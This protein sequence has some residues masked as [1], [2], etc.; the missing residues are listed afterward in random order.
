MSASNL[1]QLFPLHWHV[2]SNN[3]VEL[4]KELLKGQNNLE[5]LDPRGRTP[6]MLAV[7]LGHLESTRLLLK[8]GADATFQD[9]KYWSVV[10]EATSTG[11]P[12]LVALILQ[13]RDAQREKKKTQNIPCLLKILKE[14]PDFYVE[15]KWEFSSWVPLISRVCPS[16]TYRV[17]KS[18]AQ[19]RIDTTLIGFDNMKWIRGNRSCV[20]KATEN[21][22]EVL[23][24]DHDT[25]TTRREMLDLQ[26]VPDQILQPT[27]DAV[28]VR[29]TSPIATTFIDVDRISFE[30]SKS[31]I[32]GWRSDRSETLNGLECKVFSASNVEIITQSRSEHLTEL[33]KKQSKSQNQRTILDSLLSTVETQ[34][35]ANNS[36]YT[37]ETSS[38]QNNPCN[39]TPEEYFNDR[40]DLQGRDIGRPKETS[41]KTQRFKATLWLSEEFPLNLQ[42]QVQPIID[43]M[44]VSNAH[45]QKLKDFITLQLPSGFPV[46][47]E[48]PLFHVINARITF[49]NIYSLKNPVENVH[50]Y[51]DGTVSRC[52][53]DDEVF[54]VGSNYKI[55]Q[56]GIMN[57]RFHDEDE[58]LLR[59]AIKQSLVESGTER[60]QVTLMEALNQSKPTDEPSGFLMASDEERAL[61]RALEESLSLVGAQT[62]DIVEASSVPNVDDDLM[63]AI[64]MSVREQ[65]QRDERR[66]K[67]DEELEQV[68][69]LSMLEK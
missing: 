53:I 52:T 60:D 67:E 18:G 43:L 2:W 66:R 69:K 42:E 31:G 34:K 13:H 55:L 28:A 40:I 17:W 49:D 22:A 46:K 35:A 20:F 29:L 38:T 56:S 36:Q 45:F 6:L 59:F 63:L 14:S 4:D 1:S 50:S 39:I 21:G 37:C 61:Q 11:D 47:I 19:V 32:W 30:R 27:E 64:D 58:R 51:Q 57:P 9:K 62:N 68:L 33:D 5:A 25:R 26:P 65:E 7:V 16:D 8:F 10:H 23:E 15:M 3:Y 12:E 54:D 24:I 41:T 44:A 48:I